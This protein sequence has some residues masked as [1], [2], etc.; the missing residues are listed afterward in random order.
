M[1]LVSS[2]LNHSIPNRFTNSRQQTLLVV[3]G[4]PSMIGYRATFFFPPEM[5]AIE[6]LDRHGD[7]HIG[8][9]EHRI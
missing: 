5:I 1:S 4:K 6:H 2:Q 7:C 3:R 9:Y 8:L